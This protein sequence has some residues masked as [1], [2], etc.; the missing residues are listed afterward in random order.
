M[1]NQGK[2]LK[3]IIDLLTPFALLL[4]SFIGLRVVYHTYAENATITGVDYTYSGISG[5]ICLVLLVFFIV[6]KIVVDRKRKKIA[7]VEE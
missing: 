5:L 6:L 7:I 4:V 1:N 2:L 3:S